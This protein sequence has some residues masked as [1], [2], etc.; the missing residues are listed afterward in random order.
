M[1]LIKPIYVSAFAALILS[2]CSPALAPMVSTNATNIDKLPLKTSPVKE[3][4][5][6]R[7]SH[8]DLAK[9]T[10]PGMSTDKA[11]NEFLKGKKEQKLLLVLS[12]LELT[13]TMRI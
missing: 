9:D 6:K 8:L 7:W 12:I 3:D 11:Y 5:L 4:D 10:I 2:S 1:K 13:L